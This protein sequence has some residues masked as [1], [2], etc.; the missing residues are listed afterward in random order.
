MSPTRPAI[1]VLIPAFNEAEHIAEAVANASALGTV[2]VVDAFSTDETARLAREAGATV[3]QREFTG[4]ADQKN[5]ALDHLPLKGQWVF[6]LDADERITPGLRREVLATLAAGGAADGYFVK[7]VLVFM[8]RAIRHGGLSPSWELRLFRRGRARCEDRAVNERIVCAGATAGLRHEL[9]HV[10]RESMNAFLARQIRHADL[11]SDERVRQALGRG[12][13]AA[14]QADWPVRL[15]SHVP[16]RPA[17]R[18][19]Y[20]FVLRLGFLDGRAGW[21]LARLTSCYDYMVGLLYRDKLMRATESAPGL[22]RAP[23]ADAPATP[24]HTVTNAQ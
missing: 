19:L 1:D 4:Y 3:V 5:W 23:M 24:A 13:A 7:R 2:F 8:G 12:G 17:W 16:A 15:A 22:Q 10:R 11:E 21:H 9:L 18:L 14:R 6:V 20:L